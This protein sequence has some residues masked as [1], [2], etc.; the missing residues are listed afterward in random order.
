M[1]ILSAPSSVMRRIPTLLRAG[2]L[3]LACLSPACV[4]TIGG[5]SED[6]AAVQS[7]PERSAFPRLT[8]AQWE[9]S[10]RDVLRLDAP[11]GFSASFTGD[12]LGGV[13][14]NNEAV[15]SVTPNLWADYQRAA[16]EL[17]SLV[18]SDPAKVDAL[19]PADEGQGNE[20]RA[21]AF[22]E[23]VG[24][25]AYRRP[26][27][28]PEIN[29]LV[30]L[31]NEA[32]SLIDGD[33]FLAGVEHVLSAL[34]QS[35]HFIYRVEGTRTPRPDGLIPLGPYERA[36]RLS[37]L[38]WNTMPDDVLFEA[39]AAGELDTQEG[40]RTHAERMLADPQARDVVLAFHRQLFDFRKFEDLYKDPAVFPEFVPEIGKDLVREAELFVEDVVFEQEG[41]L[42]ALLTSRTA[43]VNDR[44]AGIYEVDA[45][46]G[47]EFGKVEL[48][49]EKRSGIL[50]RAGFLAANGT[51][52]ASDPIHR[53][54]FVNLR[55][56]CARLPPPPNN[57]P[58]LP[59]VEGKTT[60][61]I[62]ASHTGKG[63]CG[64]SCHGTLINPAGFAF[65]NYDAIGRYRA[66]DN[67]FPVDAADAYPLGGGMASFSDALTWSQ[68]LA[69][70]RE[71]NECFAKNW[72][73]F[74][75]GR[76]AEVEDAKFIAK[77]GEASR[78]GMSVKEL[79]LEL[80][81]SDAFST[82]RPVEVAQ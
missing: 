76:D 75:Y 74:A 9:N 67:G 23:A 34:F 39:A 51:A 78:T 15:L 14:D 40:L 35:P 21:R 46:N 55:V 19:V 54:V 80:V 52:R 22:I 5:S 66:E 58:P 42:T 60:R 12:P 41:G 50:T 45:P 29:Q 81:S 3:V 4:G 72:L 73:E 24:K 11:P 70:S 82:R 77:L 1:E 7:I 44:L 57:V 71:A 32:P 27:T 53:G 47:A 38:L 6:Q 62:V 28:A 2:A 49:A 25:R 65:E 56:L 16:E 36:A 10:V 59:P 69:E 68:L 30:A 79:L 48:D 61:E 13:F 20:A 17:A 33:P 63:T 31:F 64:A 18:V 26:L 8:H 37:Y 43:F